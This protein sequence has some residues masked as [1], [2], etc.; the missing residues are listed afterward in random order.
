MPPT[1][2]D[3]PAKPPNSFRIELVMN[4]KQPRLDVIL[5]EA[6]RKQERN[7]DLK[8]ISRSVFKN[9]FKTKR[10]LIKGQCAKPSSSVAAGTTYVDILG[11]E[12]SDL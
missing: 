5:L 2:T 4:N 10:I 8:R 6:I 7:D 3:I 11:Y 1:M 9:L 12:D